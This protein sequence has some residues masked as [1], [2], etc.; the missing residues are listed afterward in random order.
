MVPEQSLG[1]GPWR[2]DPD[3]ICVW[4]GD[5]ARQLPPKAFAVLC[6]LVEHPGRVITK[7]EIYEHLW[8]GTVV[9]DSVLSV[10]MS[11]LCEVLGDTAR[12]PQFIETVHRLGYRFIGPAPLPT[13]GAAAALA[14]EVHQRTSGNPLF[15]VTMVDALVCRGMVW[16]EAERW[17]VQEGSAAAQIGVP[18]SLR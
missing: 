1:G 9:S 18:E 8:P 16:Q 10:Y 6:Y 14:Q 3:N 12:A 4:R 7:D 11:D 15:M 13:P 17:R 2:L 5:T